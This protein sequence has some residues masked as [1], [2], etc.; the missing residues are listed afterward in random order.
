[1]QLRITEDK[2]RNII[3]RKIA[4]FNRKF[5]LGKNYG[6]YY[7]ISYA[8]ERSSSAAQFFGVLYAYIL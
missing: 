1:M 2:N 7:H 5:N 8:R 6:T 4:S 3:C